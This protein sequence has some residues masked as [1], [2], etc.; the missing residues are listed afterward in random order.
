[1]NS[2]PARRRCRS[3]LLYP[4]FR[5]CSC[6]PVIN[7]RPPFE[8]ISPGDGSGSCPASRSGSEYSSAFPLGVGNPP[9]RERAPVL[10]TVQTRVSLFP[11]PFVRDPVEPRMPA[12]QRRAQHGLV[13]LEQVRLRAAER[14]CQPSKELG[15]RHRLAARRDGR[16]I[17]RE[18]QV[19]PGRRQIQMLDLAR[20]R[21][22]VVGV[23]RGLGDEQVV[24]DREQ[25]VAQE[26]F[27]NPALIRHRHHRVGAVHDE[28]SDRRLQIRS[29]RSLPISRMFRTRTPGLC[30]SGL[31]TL[32]MSRTAKCSLCVERARPPPRCLHAPVSTGRQ[33]MY[34]TASRRCDGARGR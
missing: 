2:S 23:E 21:Q 22:H 28:R 3:W 8:R 6:F 34:G 27:P 20:G 17:Q 12:R 26:T 5:K 29:Q 32:S 19:A 9:L 25:V 1:M 11:Q 14:L 15:V 33:A 4:E 16:A 24:H 7:C 30:T 31:V 18:I 13:A 10:R